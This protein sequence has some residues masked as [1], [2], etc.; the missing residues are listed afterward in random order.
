MAQQELQDEWAPV[1]QT[2]GTSGGT[3]SQGISVPFAQWA[4]ILSTVTPRPTPP[5][6]RTSP[7]SPVSSS[8]DSVLT[9]VRSV[10][11]PRPQDLIHS[12]GFSH[13]ALLPSPVP[14]SFPKHKNA[15][16]ATQAKATSALPPGPANQRGGRHSHRSHDFKGHFIVS[17]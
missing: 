6:Q 14:I 9:D 8:P 3:R 13:E 11:S 17:F 7:R 12:P 15:L 4:R 2:A 1:P 16:M 10:C 5:L